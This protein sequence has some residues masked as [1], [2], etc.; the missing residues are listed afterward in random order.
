M[1][2][3]KWLN[4]VRKLRNCCNFIDNNKQSDNNNWSNFKLILSYRLVSRPPSAEMI[5]LVAT[6]VVLVV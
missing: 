5:P 1:V 4:K 3:S 6:K 2:R